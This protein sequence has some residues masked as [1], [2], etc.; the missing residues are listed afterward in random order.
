LDRVLRLRGKITGYRDSRRGFHYAAADP[1]LDLGA[2]LDGNNKRHDPITPQLST[3]NPAEVSKLLLITHRRISA[4]AEEVVRAADFEPVKL[5]T[6]PDPAQADFWEALV[7]VVSQLDILVQLLNK[8]NIEISRGIPDIYP[9]AN[10][11][12]QVR[13]HVLRKSASRRF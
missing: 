13:L 6:N 1:T 8:M 5:T 10:L 12:W 4:I 11:A 7:T 3:V 2:L 9:H